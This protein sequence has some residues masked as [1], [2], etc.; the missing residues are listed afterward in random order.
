MERIIQI[1]LKGHGRA[2]LETQRDSY[3]DVLTCIS[4]IEEE[5]AGSEGSNDPDDW[6]N[7]LRNA[8]ITSKSEEASQVRLLIIVSIPTCTISYSL[9]HNSIP[10]LVDW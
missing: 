3:L 2:A 1:G 5:P 4:L 6:L 10:L 8:K 7:M 9:K